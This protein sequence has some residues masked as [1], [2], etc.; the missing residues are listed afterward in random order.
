M[1]KEIFENFFNHSI[2][3]YKIKNI[4]IEVKFDKHYII[5][6]FIN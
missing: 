1:E 4:D 6:S 3:K 2:S 5:F